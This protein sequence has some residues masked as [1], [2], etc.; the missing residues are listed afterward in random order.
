MMVKLSPFSVLG[1]VILLVAVME[2]ATICFVQL[3]QRPSVT[4]EKLFNDAREFFKY[5]SP[6]PVANIPPAYKEKFKRIDLFDFK[7]DQQKELWS[8]FIAKNYVNASHGALLVLFHLTFF[9]RITVFHTAERGEFLILSPL[10][11][12]TMGACTQ[13]WTV[14]RFSACSA[15]SSQSRWWRSA[16]GGLPAWP[17]KPSKKTL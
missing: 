8:T 9:D 7:I 17:C 3:L 12:E 10:F 14:C 2:F 4:Y 11:R 1:L 13:T 15:T 6:L 5:E 16:R